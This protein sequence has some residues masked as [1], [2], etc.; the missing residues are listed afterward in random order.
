MTERI[1]TGGLVSIEDGIKAKEEYSPARKVRV[2]LSFDTPENGSGAA[3]TLD[4][5]AALADRKVKELLGKQA[6]PSGKHEKTEP[7]TDATPQPVV[8]ATATT[9]KPEGKAT[10]RRGPKAKA[11][12]DKDK[13]AE[14]AGVPAG[15]AP[16]EIALDDPLLGDT[17]TA[18]TTDANG[19]DLISSL[20]DPDPP[21]EITDAELNRIVSEHLEKFKAQPDE[22]RSAISMAIRK[23]MAQ[24]IGE[25]KPVQLRGI[26]QEKRVEF[27]GVVQA[28]K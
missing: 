23:S 19:D 11:Q 7:K 10:T 20:D 21:R 17:T 5:V 28:I 6:V 27:I 14:A 12:S 4:A 22:K 9:E 13:L 16:N 8:E 2:E 1:I 24:Y 18:T 15:A 25:G 26:P 3:L